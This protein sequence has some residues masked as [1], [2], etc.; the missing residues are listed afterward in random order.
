MKLG[1]LIGLVLGVVLGLC[2]GAAASRNSSGTMSAAN[3]PYVGGTVINVSQVN[4]R[5]A[6]IESEI[7]DSLSRSG[8]GSMTAALKV[9]DSGPWH[10]RE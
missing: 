3:G 4:S 10:C 2:V 7:T 6:D 1:Y 5:F 9:A 8:K